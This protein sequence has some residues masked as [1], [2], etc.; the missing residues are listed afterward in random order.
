MLAPRQPLSPLPHSGMAVSPSSPLSPNSP[1]PPSPSFPGGNTHSQH[2]GTDIS[3]Q[4]YILVATDSVAATKSTGMLNRLTGTNT[5]RRRYVV[6]YSSGRLAY[7][8]HRDRT[9]LRGE[10]VLSDRAFVSQPD[11]SRLQ[12]H[13]GC[14]NH[15]DQRNEEHVWLTFEDA[16]TMD[17]YVTEL[18]RMIAAARNARGGFGSTPTHAELLRQQE[19][20]L[21]ASDDDDDSPVPARQPPSTATLASLP[22]PPPPVLPDL[23]LPDNPLMP[24]TPDLASLHALRPPTVASQSSL[25]N[26]A[27]ER[28]PAP[29]DEQTHDEDPLDYYSR[30]N[31]SHPSLSSHPTHLEPHH[32]H[33]SPPPTPGHHLRRDNGPSGPLP[34]VPVHPS[35]ANEEVTTPSRH[36]S[37]VVPPRISVSTRVPGPKPVVRNDSTP[38]SPTSPSESSL[39]SSSKRRTVQLSKVEAMKLAVPPPPLVPAPCSALPLPPMPPMPPTRSSS[40]SALSAPTRAIPALDLSLRPKNRTSIAPSPASGAED[41]DEFE[42]KLAAL[43][44][45]LPHTT[46]VHPGS[47]VNHGFEMA[48]D[49]GL[50]LE[51][52]PYSSL[53]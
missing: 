33:P 40:D 19:D 47:K 35:K 14:T 8:K 24:G 31:D 43:K 51:E 48:R 41:L 20:A 6:L 26:T 45:V 25:G 12:L 53:S 37:L 44:A 23:D 52:Q 39:G 16:W 28:T 29:S 38:I 5:S 27:G 13:I 34:P 18:K 11:P 21:L 32:V 22:S 49:S 42:R 50:A 3:L 7:Y 17:M 2:D 30:S 9:D 36:D 46:N 1:L 4:H 15:G 10:L